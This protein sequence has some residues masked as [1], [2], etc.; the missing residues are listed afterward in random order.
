VVPLEQFHW[1]G[2]D[3]DLPA[4]GLLAFGGRC[5]MELEP[6]PGSTLAGA[7]PLE[8]YRW[9]SGDLGQECRWHEDIARQGNTK[10]TRTFLD[11]EL[12]N[13]IGIIESGEVSGSRR[14]S[15]W[16]KA[17]ATTCRKTRLFAIAMELFR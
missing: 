17:T 5:D 4:S 3:G 14:C 10:F 7:I 2:K 16:T 1:N 12:F 6:N 13:S 9:S 8:L 11:A 15:L